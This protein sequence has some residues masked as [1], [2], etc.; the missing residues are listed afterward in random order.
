MRRFLHAHV[1]HGCAVVLALA[2]VLVLM[3]AHDGEQRVAAQRCRQCSRHSR[4]RHEHR[5]RVDGV[6]AH[7]PPQMELSE[8]FVVLWLSSRQQC[9]GVRVH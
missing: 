6:V 9:P 1:V 5:W 8:A 4:H 3:R 7:L 2:L